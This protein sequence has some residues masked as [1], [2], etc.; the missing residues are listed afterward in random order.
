MSVGDPGTLRGIAR[1]FR[2][3]NE[4]LRSILPEGAVG[5]VLWV[6]MLVVGATALG[7]ALYFAG[8]GVLR[9]WRAG[10]TPAAPDYTQTP[11][12]LAARLAYYPRMLDALR[13]AGLAKPEST[14]PLHHARGLLH[15]AQSP[16]DADVA[17]L[18]TELSS[19]Y[20]ALRFGGHDPAGPGGDEGERA[21]LSDLRTRLARRG[22]D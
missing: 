7:F 3:M 16:A 12:A 15:Q 13:S 18:V 9:R 21:K 17:R 5:S 11:P 4:R 8:R 6:F 20:Y 1:F 19:R 10:R 2:S 14:P 22:R